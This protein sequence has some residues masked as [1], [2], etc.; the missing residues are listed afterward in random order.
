[1]L[2]YSVTVNVQ[3]PFCEEWLEWMLVDHIP[4]VMQTKSFLSFQLNEL[5]DPIQ[6]DQSISY[7]I[8]YVS[9]DAETLASYRLNYAPTLQAQHQEKFGHCTVAFR[10]ILAVLKPH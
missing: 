9:P 3:E 1:M 5:L 2:I 6:D 7:N 8:Q 10:T 4:A